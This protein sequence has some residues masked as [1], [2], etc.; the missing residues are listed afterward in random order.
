MTAEH[1]ELRSFIREHHVHF[2]IAARSELVDG[3]RARVGEGVR[4]WAVHPKRTRA[5]PGCEHCR[6]LFEKLRRF[7]VSVIGGDPSVL[8]TIQPFRPAL[9]E[10]RVV[11]DADEVVLELWSPTEGSRGSQGTVSEWSKRIRE[12]LREIGV[13]ER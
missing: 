13:P 2:D 7:A 8:G 6:S 1:E 4:L 12:A 3:Q 11:T 9:Y 5:L 10:S